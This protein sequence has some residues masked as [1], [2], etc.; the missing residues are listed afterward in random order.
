MISFFS[1]DDTALL[2]RLFLSHILTDFVLQPAK[3]SADK[4]ANRHRSAYLYVHALVAGLAAYALA[5]HWLSVWIIGVV[6]VT[7]GFIDWLK[8]HYGKS[9]SAVT[10]LLDQFLHGLTIVFVWVFLT[11][12]WN[13]SIR[14]VSLVFTDA[15]SMAILVGYTICTLPIGMIVGMATQRWQQELANES[16]ASDTLIDAGKW[17]GIAERTLIFTFVLL[18]QYEAIGFLI[19]AKS[20]LRFRE[21]EKGTKHSEYVLVGTLLSYGLAILVGLLTKLC[22]S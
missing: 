13:K 6:G 5:G 16:G 11:N 9:G 15:G 17:I 4:Q 3:W 8:M 12:N 21:G 1:G 7:H 2:F 20:L 22:F 18:S 10:V 19:A 14:L